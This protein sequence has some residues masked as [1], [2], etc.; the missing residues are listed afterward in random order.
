[1]SYAI[2][3]YNSNNNDY[4]LPMNLIDIDKLFT[5]YS[6]ED[7]L[8]IMHN[9]DSVFIGNDINNLYISKIIPGPKLIREKYIDIICDSKYLTFD[10]KKVL[11]NNKK[12]INKL[13]KNLKPFLNKYVIDKLKKEIIYLDKDINLFINNIDKL[14]YNDQRLIRSILITY[15]EVRDIL[16]K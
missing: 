7:V 4:Y 15:K 1:M 9:F 14:D 12:I 10:I 6:K 16:D 2:C 3:Y 13:S 5:K 8:K 11:V